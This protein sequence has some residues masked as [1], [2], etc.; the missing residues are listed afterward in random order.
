[1]MATLTSAVTPIPTDTVIPVAI[2]VATTVP[3]DVGPVVD[4]ALP[5][6]MTQMPDQGRQPQG[7]P[8]VRGPNNNAQGTPLDT[9][10]SGTGNQPSN[11]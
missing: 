4:T 3:V 10:I 7:T 11:P 1:M 2:P 6:N 9:P 8:S 5:P